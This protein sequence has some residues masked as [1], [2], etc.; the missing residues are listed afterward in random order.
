MKLMPLRHPDGH[1]W[2][3]RGNDDAWVGLDPMMAAAEI[4]SGAWLF[5]LNVAANAWGVLNVRSGFSPRTQAWR[6]ASSR[7]NW[8]TRNATG[9]SSESIR[10]VGPNLP[11]LPSAA[12][13]L[14]RDFSGFDSLVFAKTTRVT[15]WPGLKSRAPSISATAC[16]I[17]AIPPTKS[18]H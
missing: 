12:K 5:Y 7:P 9:T 17:Q 8:L 16:A 2:L 3:A 18:G 10:C 4:E 15:S 1:T 6:A 11:C 14:L 13:K